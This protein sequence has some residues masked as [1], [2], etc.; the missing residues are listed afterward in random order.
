[1]VSFSLHQ[2][3]PTESVSYFSS[4]KR[5][6][7]LSKR[8]K[9]QGQQHTG[10]LMSCGLGVSEIPTPFG[11]VSETGKYRYFFY[12]LTLWGVPWQAGVTWLIA[13]SGCIRTGAEYGL[14]IWGVF[15]LFKAF[16]NWPLTRYLF[17]K[18]K[19]SCSV[20]LLLQQGLWCHRFGSSGRRSLLS[21][22]AA[23]TA[24]SGGHR[25]CL[26]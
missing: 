22:R 15:C 4:T 10:Q 5:N 12:D 14:V 24:C 13:P 26:K 1:M 19:S 11:D 25:L 2:I 17:F 8:G 23:G 21:T 6:Y 9:R 16:S 7:Q 3:Q 20:P 18:V